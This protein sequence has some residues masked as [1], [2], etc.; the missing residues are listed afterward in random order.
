MKDLLNRAM[1]VRLASAEQRQWFDEQMGQ[2]HYLGA[3]QPV[4]DYLRQ[5]VQ[6]G[7]QPVALL[8]W[9]P[10]CYA[11]KDRD[12]WLSWSAPQRVERLKLIVQNRRFLLLTPKGQAPNL[13]SQALATALRA[14]PQQW[15]QQFGYRPLLAE[16]FTDPEAYAGTCYKATNWQ[17]VGHSAGY[18]RHRADFYVFNDR[19]KRLWLYELAPQARQHL[20]ALRVPEDCWGG[21]VAGPS[22]L[23]PVKAEQMDSLLKVFRKAPDPRDTN[24]QYRTG[25]VLTIIALALLAGRREIAEIARF[26]TTL[27]QPQRRRLGLPLKKGTRFCKVPGYDVFYQMLTR[28]DPEAFAQLLSQWLLARAGTLPQALALDGKM[29]REHIGLLTLAQHEDGAPQA[30]AVYDQKEGTERCELNAAGTLL[31]KLPSLDGKMITADPLHCQRKH[32]RLIVEKGGDYL[33]QIKGNQSNLLSQAQGLD[34]LTSTPFLSTP[35]P[36]T[37]AS[38]PDNSMPS[39]LNP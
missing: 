9:G 2:H 10:A 6:I 22:G 16:S 31:E 34:A 33:L 30:I 28:M 3:G 15:T 20:R 8:V 17:A 5:I 14:L 37:D 19:P 32:A 21:L 13:A 26:A 25:P 12:L 27:T 4:G 39:P 18:S 36:D 24:T 23:L 7:G 1:T 11:L 35:S 29:I 38:K